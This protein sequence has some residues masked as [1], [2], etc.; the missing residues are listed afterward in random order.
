MEENPPASAGPTQDM[1]GLSFTEFVSFDLEHRLFV[2]N[3]SHV[4]LDPH[5]NNLLSHLFPMLEDRAVGLLVHSPMQ[6]E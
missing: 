3:G 6:L 5:F 4:T 2:F 1:Y